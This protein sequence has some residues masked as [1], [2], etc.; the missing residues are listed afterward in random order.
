MHSHDTLKKLLTWH[1]KD[2]SLV[3]TLKTGL[4][5]SS[6]IFFTIELKNGSVYAT[7]IDSIGIVVPYMFKVED[8]LEYYKKRSMK[9]D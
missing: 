7:P 2:I 8:P 1:L 3:I 9:R 4:H 5:K 6:A